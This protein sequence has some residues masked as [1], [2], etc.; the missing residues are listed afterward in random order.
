MI[1]I[2]ISILFLAFY[3]L[4]YTSK[5]VHLSYNLGFENWMKKN[6]KSTKIIGI[7]LLVVAYLLWIC[8]T[9]FGVGTLLFFIALM[10][11]AS[12]IVILKPL[13]ITSPKTVLLLFSIMGLLEVYYS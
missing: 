8:V 10:T 7:T 1:T 13:K 3:A 11:I 4:Y 12:L 9:A 2:A 5:R 6:P